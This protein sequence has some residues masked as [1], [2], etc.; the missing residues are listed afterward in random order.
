M[1]AC[2]PALPCK[3]LHMSLSPAAVRRGVLQSMALVAIDGR[4]LGGVQSV[5][6][7]VVTA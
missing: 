5:A 1:Q 4:G 2:R 6:I 3:R 7:S